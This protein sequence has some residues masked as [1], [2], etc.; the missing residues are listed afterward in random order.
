[1]PAS[2][3]PLF[4]PSWRRYNQ[5][6]AEER[7]R[8]RV[9]DLRQFLAELRVT[10]GMEEPKLYVFVDGTDRQKVDDDELFRAWAV[11][12]ATTFYVFEGGQGKG[13]PPKVDTADH[14]PLTA[15]ERCC[16]TLP[17]FCARCSGSAWIAPSDPDA[18]PASTSA[19][20]DPRLVV[21]V[22]AS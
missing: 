21:C 19:D 9:A 8:S 14:T 17:M 22:L 10:L 5:S 4:F 3:P 18:V 15:A 11:N 6:A 7:Q 2:S 1:V 16:L 20:G 13:S 12:P